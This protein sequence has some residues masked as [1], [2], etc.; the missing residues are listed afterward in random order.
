MRPISHLFREKRPM[1][2]FIGIEKIAG[3]YCAFTLVLTY[4]LFGDI[5]NKVGVLGLRFIFIIGTVFLWRLYNR[6]PCEATY[7]LRIL[8]QFILLS[9]WYPDIYNFVRLMPN[10]DYVTARIDQIMFGFQPS[11][12]FSKCLSGMF[13]QELF[14]MGYFSYFLIIMSIVI[15]PFFIYPHHL[16]RSTFVAFASFFMFYVLFLFIQVAGPQFYFVDNLVS[17]EQ[18][19]NGQFPNVGS[20]FLYHSELN[21]LTDQG[22]GF[23][24]SLIHSIHSSERPIAAFPSSHVGISTVILLLAFKIKKRYAYIILPFYVILCFSTVYIQAHYV[25]DVFAGL[26]FGVL[27][28]WLG[29][30]LYKMKAFRRLSDF[31]ALHYYRGNEH[32]SHHHGHHHHHH[33]HHSDDE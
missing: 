2:G 3:I 20:Y 30:M 26:V 15:V 23:F 9:Y 10:F 18:I 33:H 13:W 6:V 29:N 12:E 17:A 14:N 21:N 4:M 25:I 28:Y 11:I 7:Y 16:D 19:S 24:T 22:G 27:F 31:S 1:P 32:Y 8:F 5:D